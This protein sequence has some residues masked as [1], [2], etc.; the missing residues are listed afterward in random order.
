MTP[1]PDTSRPSRRPGRAAAAL[2]LA[3]LAATLPP[4]APAAENGERWEITST[5]SMPG[6]AMPARTQATC[7]AP[8]NDGAPPMGDD[9]QCTMQEVQRTGN[10]LRFK[11]RCRSGDTGSGELVYK[12]RDAYVGTIQVTHEGQTMTMKLE[13]R[14]LPGTCD[15]DAQARQA[16]AQ[17]DAVRA[18]AAGAMAQ[19]CGGAVDNLQPQILQQRDLCEPRYKTAFCEKLQSPDGFAML[20]KRNHGMP[21]PN[22]LDTAGSFCGT[23]VPALRTRLCD[24]AEKAERLGFLADACAGEGRWGLAIAQRECAGR[25]VSSPV[26]PKYRE[27]CSAYAGRLPAATGTAAA[28][29]AA[30]AASAAS[31]SAVQTAKDL[32]KDKAG[33]AID[34]GKKLL[35]GLFN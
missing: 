4:A 28:P 17:A 6:M 29:A 24:D 13:G 10:T 1:T 7:S 15:P 35:K 30:P 26:A 2:G 25:G 11:T 23:P 18:Q 34:A 14:R 32:A 19:V 9:G 21:S 22:E 12:G 31:A 8:R 27:F 16:N 3:A 20:A 5:M 33:E